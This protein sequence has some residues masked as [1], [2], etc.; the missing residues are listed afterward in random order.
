MNI[1]LFDINI[2]IFIIHLA[3]K[4]LIVYI[5]YTFNAISKK[6]FPKWEGGKIMDKKVF[7]EERMKLERQIGV[8]EHMIKTGSYGADGD[9]TK[10]LAE[11]QL[12]AMELQIKQIDSFNQ[13]VE[14][15][16]NTAHISCTCG[17]KFFIDPLKTENKCP[18]CKIVWKMEP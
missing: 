1:F 2:F 18:N 17:T 13:F 10:A 12:M 8:L 5:E 3:C 14:E 7:T 6:Y 11:A 4:K 9:P 15:Y 16:D